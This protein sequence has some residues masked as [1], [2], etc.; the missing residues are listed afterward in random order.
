MSRPVV[1]FEDT[2]YRNLLP[3]THTRPACGLRCGIDTLWEKVAASYPSAPVIVHA[4]GA[5]AGVVAEEVRS[6][7]ANA[8]SGEAALLV[9]GRLVAPADLA[10]R[11]PLDGDDGVYV[12]DGQV[13]AARV[14]G[15]CAAS[16][17]RAMA[18]GPL[19][20]EAAWLAGLPSHD[21]DA[22]LVRFP[23]DLVRWNGGQINADLDRRGLAGRIEGDVHPSAVLDGRERIHVAAG[24][25]VHAG[26]ILLAHDGA[27]YIGPGAKVM[28]GAAVEG[29][30][31]LGDHSLIKIQSKIYEGTSTGPY[32]KIGGEIEESIFQG[33]S[34]KQH[35]GFLGHACVGE[36]VNLGADTN[37]SDLKNNYSTVRLVIDG[38][39]IDSGEQFMGAVIG[40]HTKTGIN[41]MLNTGTVLGVG[42]N[43][44]GA[45]FPPKSVPSFC[46]GGAA[47]LVEHKLD[48]FFATAEKVMA[49]R[50]RSLTEAHRVLLQAV[51]EATSAER[52]GAIRS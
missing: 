17:A 21:L 32:C 38:K 35:D 45:D 12:V 30:V 9:N 36:W 8:W 14:S 24:A 48:K 26:A 29:P 42:C 6:V 27:I 23:W 51:F 50:K 39:E 2:G 44:Y 13:A 18:E 47:G 33:Y 4:R 34:S 49:R 16:V 19:G 3:L 1:I 10:A 31:S 25:E 40:D 5:V 37:N 7:A 11:V 22:H 46:W 52:G 41:T 43:V 28:A 20:D 15:K